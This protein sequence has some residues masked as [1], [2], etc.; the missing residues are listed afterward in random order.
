MLQESLI[1]FL[2]QKNYYAPDIFRSVGLTAEDTD[3]L[4]TGVYGIVSS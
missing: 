1:I 4:A 2:L 3:I